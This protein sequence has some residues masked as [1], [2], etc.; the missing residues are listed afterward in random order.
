MTLSRIQ[1]EDFKPGEGCAR[2]LHPFQSVF[3]AEAKALNGW[4]PYYFRIED[5]DCVTYLMVLT[6]HFLEG[7]LVFAYVPMGPELEF[8]SKEGRIAELGRELNRELPS[9]FVIRF[10]F[11]F[12][13]LNATGQNDLDPAR[14]EDA[15]RAFAAR[16]HLQL[17]DESIQPQGT[18]VSYPAGS[19]AYRT[20]AQRILKKNSSVVEVGFWDGSS[21][22]F[23]RWYSIYQDTARRD[24]FTARSKSY[25][26]GLLQQNQSGASC[27]LILARVAGR[28]EGGIV[29]MMND[30]MEIYMYGGANRSGDF[31]VSYPLQ[32]FAIRDAAAA[33]RKVYDFYG[34][35]G[36]A[37]RGEHLASLTQFKLSFGGRRIYRIPSCDYVLKRPVWRLY[38]LIEDYR[39]RR[40]R[41]L[42]TE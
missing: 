39:L 29:V 9:V 19:F 40:S 11:P 32:D 6:R 27:R 42:K 24:R 25:I 26:S 5:G 23:S 28:I 33:G 10:D 13:F 41:H 3:W 34:C 22:D 2:I 21:S 35:E 30:D 38:R 4:K 37:G 12:D 18:V 16:E 15:F 1:P 36:T 7:A 14:A 31:N 17:L 8:I 20:R